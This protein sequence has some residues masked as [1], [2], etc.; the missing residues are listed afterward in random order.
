[1]H[2]T[3]SYFAARTTDLRITWH[4]KITAGPQ[5]WLLHPERAN[6]TCWLEQQGSGNQ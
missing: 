5:L 1:M 6:G 3:A 2:S 4:F